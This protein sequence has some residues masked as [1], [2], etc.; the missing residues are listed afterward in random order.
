MVIIMNEAYENKIKELI[1]SGH[2]LND[3]YNSQTVTKSLINEVLKSI[4]RKTLF[5]H[6][7]NFPRIALEN[8]LFSLHRKYQYHKDITLNEESIYFDYV[9]S[10]ENIPKLAIICLGQE[11]IINNADYIYNEGLIRKTE[12]CKSAN[13]PLLIFPVLEIIDN[14]FLSTDIREAIRDNSSAEKHNKLSKEEYCNV[15]SLYVCS[16]DNY[17]EV[18]ASSVCGCYNCGSII[19]DTSQIKDMSVDEGMACPF[20]K[21]FS[22]ITESQGF[23]IDKEFIKTITEM[24]NE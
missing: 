10:E 7:W 14:P 23:I 22:L 8:A 12:I 6:G 18:R 5:L 24:Y 16:S 20:C 17:Q 21:S 1:L 19:K 4:D 11:Y 13:L 15:D 3:I 9:V 2:T